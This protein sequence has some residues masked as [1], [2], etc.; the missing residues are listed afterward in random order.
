MA[1]L[2]VHNHYSDLWVCEIVNQFI[3]ELDEQ[4]CKTLEFRILH[5]YFSLRLSYAFIDTI[6]VEIQIQF[7]EK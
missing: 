1:I 3:V 6:P 4:Q 2:H 7:L 5:Y